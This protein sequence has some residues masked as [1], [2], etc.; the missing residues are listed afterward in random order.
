[1]R[2]PGAG[3]KTRP[4]GARAPR[5]S[6]YAAA[7]DLLRF[8]HDPSRACNAVVPPIYQTTAFVFESFEHAAQL[9]TLQQPGHMYARTSNP[10]TA[11]LEHRLAALEGGQAALA[12]ASGKAAILTAILSV[13]SAGDNIV[14]SKS[15]YGGTYALFNA[16]LRQIGIEARFVD[17]ADPDNF[18]RAADERTRLFYG[19]SLSNPQLHPLPIADLA[20]RGRCYGIPLFVDN[21]LTPTLVRPLELGAAVSLLSCSKYVGGHGSALAGALVAGQRFDWTVNSARFPLL[22]TPDLAYNGMVW[23][24][25]AARL[26]TSPLILRARMVVLRDIGATLSP[27]SAFLI[28]QGAETL[29]LRMQRHCSNA[30]RVA[31]F[32]R[33]HP[34]V[35]SVTY[36]TLARGPE[37]ELVRRLLP[38]GAGGMIGLELTG[39]LEAGPRFIDALQLVDHVAN[40][41]DTRSLAIHPASTMLSQ[42]SAAE[43]SATGVPDGYVRLCIGIEDPEDLLDDIAGALEAC[44][45]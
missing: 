23:A 34:A 9:F 20:E 27:H 33:G 24:E 18:L 35:A 10:T 3:S 39:G 42:L 2:R 1:M 7:T 16:T 29:P 21:T 19:E 14:A 37:L 5:G 40:N 44:T 45:P 36:P 15:L 25:A 38:R 11:V 26:E 30:Q 12:T 22:Y 31:E 8:G 43:R 28:M 17:Q 4:M 32:L 41:G 6:G 13:A